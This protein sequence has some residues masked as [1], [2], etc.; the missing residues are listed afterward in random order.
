MWEHT[1]TKFAYNCWIT[2]SNMQVKKKM[3]LLIEE[4]KS[5]MALYNAYTVAICTIKVGKNDTKTWK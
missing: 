5:S 2:L 4:K 1:Y 3:E